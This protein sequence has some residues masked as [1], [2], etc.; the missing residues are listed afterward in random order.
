M[1]QLDDIEANEV[2]KGQDMKEHDLADLGDRRGKPLRRPQDAAA[3]RRGRTCSHRAPPDLRAP[4]DTPR[5]SRLPVAR[6][7]TRILAR[8]LQQ[9][10]H[11]ALRDPSTHFPG[12][13][14]ARTIA[15]GSA[16][17]R[18]RRPRSVG[19]GRTDATRPI[20]SA[21]AAS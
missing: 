17:G 1:S 8:Q 2:S 16:A 21:P 6:A 7:S 9:V 13:D 10:L 19:A 12:S 14:P 11:D 18:A 4:R 20:G 15:P 3:R 5:A